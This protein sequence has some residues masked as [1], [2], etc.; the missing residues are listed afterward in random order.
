MKYLL[1][2]N[3]CIQLLRPGLGEG[4]RRR[5]DASS[6]DDVGV[7]SIVRMELLHGALRSR[8]REHN[9]AQVRTLMEQFPSLPFDDAAADHAADIRT[10]L[11]TVG[12]PIGANDV[13]ISAI[14]RSRGLTLVTHNR[15]EFA[16]VPGLAIEDWQESR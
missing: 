1:D 8:Q 12:A 14:A 11:G 13:M 9:L 6:E 4:I 5:I 16:R 3:A 7:C 2:T 15:S 10:A